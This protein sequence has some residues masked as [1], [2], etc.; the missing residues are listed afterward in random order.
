[1]NPLTGAADEACVRQPGTQV[2]GKTET[3]PLPTR[4]PIP[5]SGSEPER[6]LCC[7][8]LSPRTGIM[9]AGAR[10]R[11]SGRLTACPQDRFTRLPGPS[12][13]LA[14]SVPPPPQ[15]GVAWL[16]GDRELAGR[17]LAGGTGAW[18]LSKVFERMIHGPGLRP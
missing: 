7:S 13:N 9:S 12:C 16:A 4:W 11:R 8:R 6:R 14:P 15:A 17:L 3:L 18:A 5:G 10:P 2:P 1:M